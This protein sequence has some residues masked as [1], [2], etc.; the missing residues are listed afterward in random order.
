MAT[1]SPAIP[2]PIHARFRE[3]AAQTE[4]ID[5]EVYQRFGK[6]PLEP[7]LG[8]GPDDSRVGFFGRDPG[9]DEVQHGEPFIGAGG[10]LVRRALYRALHAGKLLP[11]FAASREIGRDFYWAN[12]VPY[13]P[14]GN[15]AWS[16]RIK[17]RFQPSVA[18]LLIEQWRGDSL[19]TLGREAFL[20]F[21]LLQSR[22]TREKLDAFWLREDRFSEA[23]SITLAAGDGVAREFRL[24]P[25]PH[26]SPLNA[27]W[28]GR[29]PGLL[30]ARLQQLNVAPGTLRR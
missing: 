2:T 3:L 25:L 21:G 4:G 26:P 1:P 24:Y 15:K 10:Q 18:R 13:K 29:F 28:Y 22:E 6:D 30:D 27:S 14:F 23:I 16:T 7:I 11:D 19:I 20:W 8:L 17:Q 5:V 9:R 12:T